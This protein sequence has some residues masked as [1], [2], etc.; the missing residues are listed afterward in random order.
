MLGN[1]MHT[2]PS[3]KIPR[4][5]FKPNREFC[6]NAVDEYLKKGGKITKVDVMPE[7]NLEGSSGLLHD[8]FEDDFL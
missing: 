7:L 1:H 2:H 6:K 3:K 8:I 4:S 5:K